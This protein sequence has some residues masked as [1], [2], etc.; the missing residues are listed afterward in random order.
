MN[1]RFS[2]PQRAELVVVIAVV[3]MVLLASD[4]CSCSPTRSGGSCRCCSPS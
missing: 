4:N 2:A 1:E 3:A